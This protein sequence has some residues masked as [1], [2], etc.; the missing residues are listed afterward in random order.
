MVHVYFW[1]MQMHRS[2][3]EIHLDLK[4]FGFF[5][6]WTKIS[7]WAIQNCKNFKVRLDWILVPYMVMT[8]RHCVDFFLFLWNISCIY[9]AW[10]NNV[11]SNWKLP[12]PYPRQTK[13]FDISDLV[14]PYTSD[15]KACSD[16]RW[17]QSSLVNPDTLV[18][19]KIV[20][21]VKHPD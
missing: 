4:L 20:R 8:K 3:V 13:C 1:I 9:L 12:P 5:K 6:I 16:C 19:S 18:P 14:G 10:Q 21:I 2:L 7:R 17:I 11:W 15:S